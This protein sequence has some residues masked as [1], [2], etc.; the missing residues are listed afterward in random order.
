MVGT[1]YYVEE[2][3][4]KAEKAQVGN[5]LRCLEQFAYAPLQINM[6]SEKYPLEET[7]FG[8]AHFFRLNSFRLQ[9]SSLGRHAQSGSGGLRL[10]RE[11]GDSIEIVGLRLMHPE[12]VVF[13][14]KSNPM[15]T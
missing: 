13:C 12:A 15:L 5:L 8:G 3:K 11:L 6:E 2:V 10:L 1:L 9:G 14:P 4:Y 7:L